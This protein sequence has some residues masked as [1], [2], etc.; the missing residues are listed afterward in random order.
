M[1]FVQYQLLL[2]V[3]VLLRLKES[4]QCGK[5]NVA[6]SFSDYDSLLQP[7][8]GPLL[9]RHLSWEVESDTN[10]GSICNEKVKLNKRR[11]IAWRGFSRVY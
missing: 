10:P 7:Q 6:S 4:I 3:Q 9:S 11:Q 8:S 5:M 1:I 2:V